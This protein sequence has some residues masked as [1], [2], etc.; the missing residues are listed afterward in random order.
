MD[1]SSRG[2]EIG[3]N[4]VIIIEYYQPIWKI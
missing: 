4:G 3:F 2:K 1:A